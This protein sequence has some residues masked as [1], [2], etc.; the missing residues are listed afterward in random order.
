MGKAKADKPAAPPTA[1]PAKKGI[2]EDVLAVM[3]KLA[4]NGVVEVHSRLISDK[5][6][7][8]PDKGRN[9]VRNIMK[10]LE[11]DGKVVIEK[12]AVK[13]KG[14]RKQYVYKLKESGAS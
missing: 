5:L 6:G 3:E 8:E 14:A 4:A 7:L 10:K 2:E 9:K 12:K 13:E 1:E 11:A